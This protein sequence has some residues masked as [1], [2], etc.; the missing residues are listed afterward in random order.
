VAFGGV[1]VAGGDQALDHVDDLGDMPGHARL[2]VRR[3]H[4]Q[5]G[6]VFVVGGGVAR[7]D[8]ADR[9]AFL[10]CGGV[11]LVV[12][13]GDVARVAHAVLAVTAPQ[14][15]RQHVEHHR[16][17]RVA[18]VR[19]GV[20]CRTADVHRHPPGVERFED[21]LA[22]GGRIVQLHERGWC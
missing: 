12:D 19:V 20:H 6:K 15:A 10:L 3:R 22:A 7:G 2:E 14:Q 21:F 16:R 9:H 4:A 11:D 18:D 5:R 1:G 17:P 8:H 13:V